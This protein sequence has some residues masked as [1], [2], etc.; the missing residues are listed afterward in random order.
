MRFNPALFRDPKLMADLVVQAGRSKVGTWDRY[1]VQAAFPAGAH[2]GQ[3]PL[4]DDVAFALH[5]ADGLLGRR[6]QAEDGPAVRLR[7]DGEG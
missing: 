5:L 6:Q 2:P 1:V 3:Q 4:L 7:D